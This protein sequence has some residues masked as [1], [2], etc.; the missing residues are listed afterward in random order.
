MKSVQRLI[1]LRRNRCYVL[2]FILTVLLL[3]LTPG[4]NRAYLATLTLDRGR[5][6]GLLALAGVAGPVGSRRGCGVRVG[7]ADQPGPIDLRSAARWTG[8]A[9]L[10]YFAW[11][12]RQSNEKE[13][14]AVV[15]AATSSLFWRGLLSNLFN[16]KSILFFVFR[17]FPGLL[18]MNQAHP[19]CWCRPGGWGRST[20]E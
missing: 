7:P 17:S 15:G 9:Y 13:H 18:D 10:P 1:C 11:E 19:V 5:R 3:E 12:T 2:D 14:P 20:L 4:P 16:P 6:A 8:V